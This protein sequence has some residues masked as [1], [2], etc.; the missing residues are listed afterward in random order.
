MGRYS[1]LVNRALCVY[2]RHSSLNNIP[3]ISRMTYIYTSSAPKGLIAFIVRDVLISDNC[4]KCDYCSSC[5]HLAI[6]AITT[7]SVFQKDCTIPRND[8]QV[9]K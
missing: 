6:N 2:I 1:S 4:D 9:S 3:K 8:P 7:I 5:T